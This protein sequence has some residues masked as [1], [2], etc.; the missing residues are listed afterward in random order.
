MPISIIIPSTIKPTSLSQVLLD[1]TGCS[2]GTNTVS[3]FV[4]TFVI[5]VVSVLALFATSLTPVP[6][7]T[8]NPV[9]VFCVNVSG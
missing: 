9:V 7:S 8:V 3:P 2:G 1:L 4:I 6:D 5:V